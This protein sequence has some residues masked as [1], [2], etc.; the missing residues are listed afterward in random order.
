MTYGLSHRYYARNF[1]Q[2]PG[3]LINVVTS[4]GVQNAP[5]TGTGQAVQTKPPNVSVLIPKTVTPKPV[6]PAPAPVP[7]TSS[8]APGICLDQ[9]QNSI[10]CNDP[11][12]TYGDCGSA[13]AQITIGSL[14]L[15][16]GENQI[17]CTDPNCT[18]GDCVTTTSWFSKSTIIT[19][20]PDVAIYG[21]LAVL[22]LGGGFGAGRRR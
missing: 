21:L 14:C 1:G 12:C 13:G 20:V 15:D 16:Q 5:G 8:G 19:G 6:T 18:Y 4:A 9:G 10:A 3:S 17:D 2:L 22:L 11:N 7:I